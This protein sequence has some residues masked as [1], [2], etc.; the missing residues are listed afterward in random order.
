MRLF[1]LSGLFFLA[2]LNCVSLQ[3]DDGD[4]GIEV[5]LRQALR[6]SMTEARDAQSQ[7]AAAQAAEAQSEKDKADL[8]AKVDAL[9]AQLKSVSD[10]AAADKATADK[11]IADLKQGAQTLVVHMVDALT[12]QI[13]NLTRPGDKTIAALHQTIDGLKAQNPDFAQALDQFGADIQAW[14]TGYDEY[15][16]LANRTEAE[17]ARLAAQAQQLQR[18]VADREAK[19]LALFKL[20]EELLARYEKAG[21]GDVLLDKEPFIGVSRV[22]LQNLVQDYEDKLRDQV[23]VP[24]QPVAA[25]QPN[26]NA[27]TPSASGTPPYP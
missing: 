17:R 26:A 27:Q 7:L 19:N 4:A 13:G 3:A 18:T 20:G 24:G 14:V 6:E 10:Q 2:V 15:V 16:Q 25:I 9:T 1:A 12:A 5:R 21:V 23:V 22:K 11:T 8:Q